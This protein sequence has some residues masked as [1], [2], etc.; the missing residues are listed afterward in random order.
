MPRHP[1]IRPLVLAAA[2]AAPLALVLPGATRAQTVA[3]TPG[4][5]ASPWADSVMVQSELRFPLESPDGKGV[6]EQQWS[7][8]AAE[9]VRPRFA[10][11]VTELN[12]A[13]LTGTG[14]ASV[15]VLLILHPN[16]PDALSK[17]GEIVAE[18]GRRFDGA[19]GTRLDYPV[20][21]TP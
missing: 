14:K 12:G 17:V 2:F 15:R 13:L 10:Q 11:D 8:F 3:P 20:R 18:Y 5:Q 16:T 7:R 21:I 4:W 9:V 1:A 6:S 19:K